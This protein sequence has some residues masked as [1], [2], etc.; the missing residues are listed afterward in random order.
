MNIKK[1]EIIQ[2]KNYKRKISKI[3]K[4]QTKIKDQ[5]PNLNK[6]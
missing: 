3:N 2:I 1:K 5:L 6:Q 4:Y